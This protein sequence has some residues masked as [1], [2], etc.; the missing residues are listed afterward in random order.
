MLADNR[1]IA[2]RSKLMRGTTRR[3]WRL[4]MGCAALML[5]GCEVSSER[6]QVAITP[7][8]AALRKGEAVTLVA[9][10]GE[11][12]TWALAEPHMGYLSALRGDTVVYTSRFMPDRG[13]ASLQ[14][15]TVTALGGGSPNALDTARTADALITHL[16]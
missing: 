4:A 2:Q 11:D 13:E 8:A 12:Y 16:R 7:S 15:V 3:A 10:G 6:R 9:S 1:A 5:A 14:T